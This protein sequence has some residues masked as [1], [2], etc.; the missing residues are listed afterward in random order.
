MS[1]VDE[2]GYQELELAHCL[3]AEAAAQAIEGADT[4]SRGF[5][6]ALGNYIFV[7]GL[8]QDEVSMPNSFLPSTAGRGLL[9]AEVLQSGFVGSGYTGID[10]SRLAHEIV[11]D[12]Q[13]VDDV[14]SLKYVTPVDGVTGIH[15]GKNDKWVDD[16]E[17]VRGLAASGLRLIDLLV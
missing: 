8:L 10:A 2:V 17:F 16:A 3:A 9:L 12:H 1:L 13:F 15:H 14:L 4:D 7:S 11:T 5:A 6:L